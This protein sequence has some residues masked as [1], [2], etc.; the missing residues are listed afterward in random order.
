MYYLVQE[1][2]FNSVVV[3]YRPYVMVKCFH[4]E[5]S[6][7]IIK[8]LFDDVVMISEINLVFVERF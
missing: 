8:Y 4:T 1:I 2:L 5:V 7:V 3:N 6:T